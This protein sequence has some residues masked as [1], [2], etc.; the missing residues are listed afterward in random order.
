MFIYIRIYIC[1][2]NHLRDASIIPMHKRPMHEMN[3]S[4]ECN[5]SFTHSNCIRMQCIIHTI[6]TQYT[7]NCVSIV[8]T[9]THSNDAFISC[10]SVCKCVDEAETVCVLMSVSILSMFIIF[11]M[12][13]RDAES[14]EGAHLKSPH[15]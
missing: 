11:R 14:E 5:A 12:H 4:F 8:C 10:T 13:T 2:H 7:L 6:H 15:T 1:D 9:I 3:A